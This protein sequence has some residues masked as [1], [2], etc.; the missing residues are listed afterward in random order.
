MLQKFGDMGGFGQSPPMG[1]EDDLVDSDEDGKEPYIFFLWQ[2]ID[3]LI[4]HD[5]EATVQPGKSGE[6][7]KA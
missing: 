5:A 1:D 2:K 3:Y 4:C 6:G 7:S